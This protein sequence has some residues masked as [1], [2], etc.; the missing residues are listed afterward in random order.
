MVALFE[1]RKGGMFSNFRAF[2]LIDDRAE[3][4]ASDSAGEDPLDL[5][6]TDLFDSR[7]RPGAIASKNVSPKLL[8][9]WAESAGTSELHEPDCW[10]RRLGLG[11]CWDHLLG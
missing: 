11:D 8:S 1:I 4:G 9:G 3:L 7:R 5:C 6:P 2:V 10:R